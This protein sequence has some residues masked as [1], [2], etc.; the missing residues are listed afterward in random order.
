MC[1]ISKDVR[2]RARHKAAGLV[3]PRY[4]TE[5][6]TLPLAEGRRDIVAFGKLFF[7]SPDR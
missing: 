6:M 2:K 1:N 3:L 4:N 7:A 5:G